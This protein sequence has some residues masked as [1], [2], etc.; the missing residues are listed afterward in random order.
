MPH[1]SNCQSTKVVKNGRIHN[2]KQNHKCRVCGRQFGD[3]P[4]QKI[5]SAKTKRLIDRLL[6]E[7]LPLAGIA[8]VCESLSLGYNPHSAS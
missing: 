8:H 1:C 2:G 6:L 3:D 5:I 4:Q 7:K